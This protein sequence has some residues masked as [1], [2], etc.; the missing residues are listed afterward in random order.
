MLSQVEHYNLLDASIADYYFTLLQ[1]LPWRKM[2]WGHTQKPLPRLIYQ[3]EAEI[4]DELVLLVEQTRGVEVAGVF[5]NFYRDANDYLPYYSDNYNKDVISLSFGGD[6][7]FWFRDV[8][9]KQTQKFV[10]KNGDLLYFPASL[11]KTHQHGIPKRKSATARI[12]LVFFL[13]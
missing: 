11:N 9:T 1:M 7:N 12:S 3:G 13:A 8:K 2:M 6:A 5:C 10:L 4:L